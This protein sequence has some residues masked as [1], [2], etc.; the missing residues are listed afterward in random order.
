MALAG[1]AGRGYPDQIAPSRP[2]PSPTRPDTEH[3]DPVTP[4]VEAELRNR[5]ETFEAD[6]RAA[7]RWEDVLADLKARR[8]LRRRP[9]DTAR[10]PQRLGRARPPASARLVDPRETGLGDQFL[11]SGEHALDG[12]S[13]SAE[14]Y[15]WRCSI[16]SAPIIAFRY[17]PWSRV[18]PTKASSSRR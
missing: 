15:K 12:M 2:H 3:H 7:R 4:E 1:R 8:P 9:V 16:C 10:S 14:Q 17:N 6:A 11:Q 5:F 18:S 13:Q